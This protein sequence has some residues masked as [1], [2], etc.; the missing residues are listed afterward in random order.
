MGNTQINKPRLSKKDTI[1]ASVLGSFFGLALIMSVIMSV[2]KYFTSS[3]STGMIDK[4]I[5]FIRIYFQ[6]IFFIIYAIIG[7]PFYFSKIN[8]D[9]TSMG[10]FWN[11]IIDHISVNIWENPLWAFVKMIGLVVWKIILALGG[12]DDM[13]YEVIDF[14]TEIYDAIVKVIRASDIYKNIIN[15]VDSVYDISILDEE[16][17]ND[18]EYVNELFRYIYFLVMYIF[19]LVVLN[20][21]RTDIVGFGFISILNIIAF[22]LFSFDLGKIM[23]PVFNAPFLFV[24]FPW[25]V[26]SA[27]SG[28]I[29]YIVFRLKWAYGKHNASIQLLKNEQETYERM[30]KTFTANTVIMFCL[31]AFFLFARSWEIVRIFMVLLLLATLSLDILLFVD[32][33]KIFRKDIRHINVKT[34]QPKIQVPDFIDQLTNVFQN[35]NMNYMLNHDIDLGL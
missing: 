25:L 32:A 10:D 11:S 35:I 12:D 21:R 4:L 31:S 7:I 29:L 20:H 22:F 17:T 28:L 1:I 8:I 26:L 15:T 18:E 19:S 13:Y 14:F 33:V 9:L 3:T 5:D 2:I 24:Y 27:V 16:F 23:G 34:D 6:S 30:K